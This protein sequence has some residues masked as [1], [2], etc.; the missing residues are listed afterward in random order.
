MRQRWT[1]PINRRPLSEYSKHICDN[2]NDLVALRFASQDLPHESQEANGERLGGHTA[3]I[4]RA[5]A[6]VTR[7]CRM[8]W[9]ACRQTQN[10]QEVRHVADHGSARL[11]DTLFDQPVPHS[12]WV[13]TE[14][15]SEQSVTDETHHW[16]MG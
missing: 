6:N 1:P 8:H 12:I 15:T 9:A 7:L 10:S 16:V 11:A 3:N 2:G 4:G 5:S 14:V 13:V